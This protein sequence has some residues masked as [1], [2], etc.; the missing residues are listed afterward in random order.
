MGTRGLGFYQKLRK[1]MYYFL[2]GS[3][4][5]SPTYEPLPTNHDVDGIPYGE[6]KTSFQAKSSWQ[7]RFSGWRGGV[8]VSIVVSSFVLF[9]NAI[10]AII[11]ATR[12][13]KSDNIATAIT[14]DCT[15]VARWMTAV[16]LIINILGSL[17][18][19]ASNYCMQRLV[20]PTRKEINNA[21]ARKTWLDIRILSLRNLASISRRRVVVWILLALTSIPLH[22]L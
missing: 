6:A 15:L 16:H 8:A 12:L 10:L 3:R 21:H 9:L 1:L 20:T 2:L 22:F 11:A 19:E 18:L 13:E 14:G 17:L 5:H 4:P 7:W